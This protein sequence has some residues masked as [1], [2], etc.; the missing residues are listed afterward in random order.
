M[1]CSDR[2]PS[3]FVR[4]YII[5]GVV[6]VLFLISIAATAAYS[7]L[8][9]HSLAEI[10]RIIVIFS[11]VTLVWN[12][13]SYVE[14]PF[15]LVAGLAYPSIGLLEILHM[16]AF[17]GMG[18]FSAETNLA[19]QYWIA[20]RAEECVA[21]LAGA[22][23]VRRPNLPFA[24]I[25]LGWLAT[26]AILAGLII[27]GR[28]PDCF[29]EGRG[30][31]PFKVVTE[32]VIS[33]LFLASAVLVCIR[34]SQF[35]SDIWP[36]VVGSL[37]LALAAELAFTQYVSAYGFANY[38]GHLLLIASGYLF[39]RALV[40]EGIQKPLDLLVHQ[41]VQEG[42]RLTKSEERFRAL[43]EHSP[44]VIDQFDRDLRYIYVNPASAKLLG[45]RADA[46]IGKTVEQAAIEEPYRSAWN[47][48][49]R[50]VFKTGQPLDVEGHFSSNAHI[51]Y[52]QWRYVPEHAA[53]GAI[54]HVLV[55]GR[56]L[57]THKQA[58]EALR[59]SE[60]KYRNLFENM[61]EE[62]QFWQL[63]R[64]ERGEIRNWRLVDANPPALRTWG[65]RIDEI[66]GKTTDEIFGPGSSSRYMA[67]VQ[68]ITAEGVP[69]QF[70]DYLPEIQRY[71]RFMNIP[72]GD[73]FI[74]T[75]FDITDI[76]E[77]QKL[78]EQR[79]VELEA[80]NH[81]LEAFSYSVSHDLRA[82]LRAI[83]GFVGMLQEDYS[84]KLDVE[85]QRLLNVVRNSAVKMGRLID[86]ILAF[87]RAGRTAINLVE[88]DMTELV[89]AVIADPLAP[90]TAGRTIAIDIAEL[91]PAR[92]D[93]AMLERVW[94]NLIDNAIK[95]S[96][97]K[98]D[99]H[100]EIGA[101][102]A[103]HETV[104]YVR[105]NGIGF[106]MQYVDKLFGVFQRLHGSEIPGT[107]IGLAIVKR[108]VSRHGGRVWAEGK[109]GE[110]A[111][112]YFTMPTAGAN[113]A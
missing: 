32:Y 91:P 82:P 19:T 29:V 72:F 96:A 113:S 24:G 103:E 110:G 16:L 112:F 33:G 98:P 80:A 83:D 15:L 50:A 79:Q 48:N 41:L 95:Y 81:E 71:F 85:G 56:D 66:R 35:P 69:Y 3:G 43:A 13:R 11:I 30:L 46:I 75:G 97:P 102:V 92:G 89:R 27:S 93:H 87:S 99:A 9:F 20:F 64:D 4:D 105:D 26:G 57:T 8:L 22:C 60:A 34:R 40:A 65:R 44:D 68:K 52:Y 59:E 47:A 100:I 106:D 55:V 104:Y 25:S 17:K 108:L 21:L 31:T 90:A 18:I 94:V 36:M 73:Y 12:A 74:T 62:L 7:Y 51:R 84:G 88:I 37:I 45:T 77:A 111:T 49:I 78:I 61:T 42:E 5:Q 28:F 70:E 109:P 23:L 54:T 76:R 101:N 86:D 14:N 63:I 67:V 6:F 38:V 53:D 58:E 39:Y 10:F 107:G 2:P 1:Y